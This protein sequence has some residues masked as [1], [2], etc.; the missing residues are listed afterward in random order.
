[1]ADGH[2][3]RTGAGHQATDRASTDHLAIDRRATVR[4]STD[5]QAIDPPGTDRPSTDRDPIEHQAIDRPSTE[6]E[7]RAGSTDRAPI[8]G[9]TARVPMARPAIDRVARSRRGGVVRLD[10]SIGDP[11]GRGA[12]DRM[13]AHVRTDRGAIATTDLARPDLATTGPG[14]IARHAGRP[15]DPSRAGQV[16]HSIDATTGRSGSR[17]CHRPRSWGLTRSS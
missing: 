5:H 17:R 11:R 7:A 2:E 1:M 10:R 14:R 13:T 15:I 16:G 3:G 9:S 8:G 6:P 12:S 4:A